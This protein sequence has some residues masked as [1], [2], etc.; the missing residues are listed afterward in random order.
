MNHKYSDRPPSLNLALD[1]GENL[2]ARFAAAKRH[3]PP[4]L[5]Q[6]DAGRRLGQHHLRRPDRLDRQLRSWIPIAPRTTT[7]A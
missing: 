1:V 5:R 4:Q 6:P 2:V 3:G 7:S